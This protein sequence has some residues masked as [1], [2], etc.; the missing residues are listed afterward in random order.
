[1]CWAFL[2]KY[3]I[4]NE[5]WRIIMIPF[6]RI[7][8]Y[9]NK[10]PKGPSIID[11]KHSYSSNITVYILRDNG[12]LW[13]G[14]YNNNGEL[15]LGNVNSYT[16]Q[17][18][19]L[20]S[21]VR[22]FSHFIG[23]ITVVT[24]DNK[25]LFAGADDRITSASASYKRNTWFDMGY[26][27]S[28]VIP[29]FA[30]IKDVASTPNNMFVLTKNGNLYGVGL[31]RSLGGDLAPTG[32]NYSNTPS[33]ISTNVATIQ[34]TTDG[35]SFIKNDGTIWGFGNNGYACR[36]SRD[37]ATPSSGSDAAWVRAPVRMFS[38]YSTS[39]IMGL[40]AGYNN[41]MIVSL[42]GTTTYG[43]GQPGYGTIGAGYDTNGATG[44][45]STSPV[46]TITLPEPCAE[47]PKAGI[48]NS[49]QRVYR[50]VD[51]FY[52]M[53]GYNP[54][55]ELGIGVDKG[56]GNNYAITTWTK[57]TVLPVPNDEVVGFSYGY[58]VS[59]MYTENSVYV[60]G[61]TNYG[62]QPAIGN[63]TTFTKITLPF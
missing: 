41:N 28:S 37:V 1:M 45:L 14:G 40:Y 46:T 8:K 19:K 22:V 61:G 17:C 58:F 52:Y 53:I 42:D 5:L 4:I 11:M 26:R 47:I 9:G 7:I 10:L 44:Y 50:G 6:A 18:V 31:G 21:D 2:V 30:D 20:R 55:G 57:N 12:E 24:N 33:L 3:N 34:I 63:L 39:N 59:Y 60:S 38:T 49:M 48:P 43:C 56:T 32:G 51:G 15:G 35:S 54:S 25:L 36:Y 23:N 29:N 13:G 62:I 16:G 27:F